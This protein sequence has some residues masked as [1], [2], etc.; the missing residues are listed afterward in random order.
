ME[1]QADQVPLLTPSDA[2]KL[3]N[4]PTQTILDMIHRKELPALKVGRH[5]R[6]L[7][8]EVIKLMLSRPR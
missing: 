8:S 7:K 6:I 4:L 2:A 3:L 5:W 1:K